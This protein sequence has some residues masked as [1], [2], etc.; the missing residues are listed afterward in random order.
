MLSQMLPHFS[1]PALMPLPLHLCPP[2]PT[3]FNLSLG[4]TTTVSRTCAYYMFICQI[5][6]I[7]AVTRGNKTP[8]EQ[9]S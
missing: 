1:S 6:S 9:A 5:P 8:D 7:L 4:P 2:V 3:G